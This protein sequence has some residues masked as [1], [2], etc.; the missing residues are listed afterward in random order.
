MAYMTIFS[1]PKSFSDPH[2]ATIQRNA[3]QSWMRL[4]PDV[5]IFL[6]GDEPGMAEVA[7]E[8]HLRQ[9]PDV[10]RN[11]AGTP[12]V[13][14]IFD[15]ARKA[16]TSPFLAYVNADILLLPEIVRATQQVA[17]QADRFLMIGQR[18]D[19][20]IRQ[21]L[22]FGQ[23]W[24]QR[25]IARTRKSGQLHAPAGSDYF[26]FPRSM[27]VEMPEFAI[28][29]AGWDNWMI[30]QAR[31]LGLPVVDATPSLLVIHQN[32]DYNHLPGGKPHYDHAESRKNEALAGGSAN[33]FMV[34]DSDKQLIRGKVRS[35]RWGLIR[36]LRQ[37]EVW[38]TSRESNRGRLNK[39]LARRLR[40]LRRRISGS[41]T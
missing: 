6:V 36:A 18:W 20:E 11:E 15:L 1:A 21:A 29:R 25:L 35:P 2:I 38:L 5:E 10:R 26:I 31:R 23:N 7:E 41:L 39:S 16:S 24:D 13:D 8:Y 28:G 19:L 30:Y 22:D 3:I 12:L 9:L 33:L 4:D 14:S 27:F 40:R 32:H 37:A 34:L 17:N